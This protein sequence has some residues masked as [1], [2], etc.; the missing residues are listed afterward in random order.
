MAIEC[1]LKEIAFNLF[2]EFI[3]NTTNNEISYFAVD[4]I[5]YYECKCWQIY[6]L[7]RKFLTAKNTIAK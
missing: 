4:S 5:Q 2:G 3:K 7:H 1:E 6:D